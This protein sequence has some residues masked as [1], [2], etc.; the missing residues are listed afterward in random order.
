VEVY[1]TA[2]R[3]DDAFRIAGEMLAKDP[4]DLQ[5]LVQMTRTGT[6]QAQKSNT[7][8]APQSLQY[9]LKAIELIEA[10]KKPAKMTEDLWAN[11]K[12]ALP[13]LYQQTAILNLVAGNI[14]EAKDRLIKTISMNPKDPYPIALLGFVL[15]DEY[16]KLIPPYQAMPAGAPKEAEKTRLEGLLDKI[17]DTYAHAAA[18]AT[19]RPEYQQLLQQVVPDLTSYYKYRHNQSTEGLQQLMDKYKPQP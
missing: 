17:I 3:P 2:N 14:Q 11:H 6:E 1:A 9:G 10:D 8:Y 7:K 12:A 18:L 4:E 16:A 15:N 19:G 13:Q 5:I